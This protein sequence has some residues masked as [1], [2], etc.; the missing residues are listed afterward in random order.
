MEEYICLLCTQRHRVM[1][2]LSQHILQNHKYSHVI[3]LG[4]IYPRLWYEFYG[5]SYIQLKTM[6]QDCNYYRDQLIPNFWERKWM[7]PQN[8]TKSVL[9]ASWSKKEKKRFNHNRLFKNH[10]LKSHFSGVHPHLETVWNGI[11]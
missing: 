4:N 6:W 1:L 7:N 3:Y 9:F 11:P 10:T 5:A 2:T 8:S